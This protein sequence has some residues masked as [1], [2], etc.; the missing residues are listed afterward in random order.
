MKLAEIYE[1]LNEP[2]KALELVFQGRQCIIS[3]D[4]AAERLSSVM[5]SRRRRPRQGNVEDGT[6]DTNMTSLFEEKARA[7]GKST[8]MKANKLN[9]AQLKELEAQKEKEVAQGFRR[10]QELWQRMLSGDEEA[11][12]EWLVEAEK[13]VESFRE[14]RNLFQTS[15]VS[16]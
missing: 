4:Y 12:R 2:R 5:D 11:E 3:M 15:R 16:P 7:K 6:E 13:L 8:S 1:I 9:V 14:T 10:V